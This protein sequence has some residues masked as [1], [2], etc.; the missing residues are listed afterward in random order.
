[1]KEIG[2]EKV[3]GC[4]WYV[5]RV[6]QWCE[7]RRCF[8]LERG[9]LAIEYSQR[10]RNVDK[11]EISKDW[12]EE[13][14]TKLKK[15][16]NTLRKEVDKNE[17][18]MLVNMTTQQAQQVLNNIS[19]NLGDSWAFSK[20]DRPYATAITFCLQKI[21]HQL[22]LLDANVDSSNRKGNKD[23]I[24][25]IDGQFG[26]RGRMTETRKEVIKLQEYMRNVLNVDT[27]SRGIPGQK[28]LV[29]VVQLDFSPKETPVSPVKER[30][31]VEKRS[32]KIVKGKITDTS[33]I[34]LGQFPLRLE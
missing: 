34:A 4:F 7:Q 1:M 10:V 32:T 9:T 8:E 28:L 22:G 16:L 2:Y 33:P 6:P 20:I 31:A 5:K 14:L 27:G 19:N 26:R 29:A 30:I 3:H 24:F 25:Y 17:E 21:C 12:I 11:G 23:G 13:D 15:R 18:I